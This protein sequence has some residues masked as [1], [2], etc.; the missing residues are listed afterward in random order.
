MN[1]LFA[2]NST[3]S[4]HNMRTLA[5]I[6]KL[7]KKDHNIHVTV[8][9][10]SLKNTFY[11]QYKS[12][13]CDVITLVESNTDHS[14]INHLEKKFDWITYVEK[15]ITMSFFNSGLILKYISLF[16]DI[17]PDVIVSDYNLSATT[18]AHIGGFK[19]ILVTE[20]YDFTLFQVKNDD[21]RQAGFEVN[22]LEVDAAKRTLHRLFLGIIESAERIITDKPYIL[23][24]DVNTA[25]ER[26]I[27]E[28]KV[29]FVG[30]MIR[31]KF[32][33]LSQ[34]DIE[35]DILKK[36]DYSESDKMIVA[37]VGGTTMFLENKKNLIN[38]YLNV[39]QNLRKKINNLKMVLISR[40]E[41]NV[42][43]PGV[44]VFDYIANWLPI[45]A[46]ANVLLSAPGWITATEIAQF[47][48]PTIFVLSSLSEYHEIEASKRLKEIGFTS[49]INPKEE[50]LIEE[51]DN[52]IS[53]VE[54]INDKAYRTLA[55]DLNPGTDRAANIIYDCANKHKAK[56]SKTLNPDHII[57]KLIL[58]NNGSTTVLLESLLNSSIY[59]KALYHRKAKESE[60]DYLKNTTDIF[61]DFDKKTIIKR[62]SQLYTDN[63]SLVCKAEVFFEIDN[64]KYIPSQDQNLPLGK[65]LINAS[66]KQHRVILKKGVADW[67]ASNEGVK[68]AFK[69]YLIYGE[70]GINL[71]V[72]E[73]YNP[74]YMPTVID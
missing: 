46:R 52:L 74:K 69:E 22:E 61:F 1:V 67:S 32:E 55:P 9:L 36:I 44:Y 11:S 63:E 65:L 21:L 2:P 50:L 25:L 72:S 70:D 12:L 71:F 51:I 68:C 6:D 49:H 60:I 19:H 34:N 4:G 38:K 57:T 40:E 59:V 20:R 33:S 3:G 29:E 15:Y 13:G 10:L 56:E 45:L 42:N 43:V 18:A 53:G 31:D 7:I 39:Y 47:K 30:P 35:T 24:F 66:K 73:K 27:F 48:I 41:I 64:S 23:K 16:I 17:K 58:D 37:S 8:I 62:K 54:K 14:K 26:A 28:G 5:L